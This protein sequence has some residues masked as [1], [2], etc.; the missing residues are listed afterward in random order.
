MAQ[1]TINATDPLESTS[2]GKINDNF[3]ELYAHKADTANPH[4]TTKTQVGLANVDN[5]QQLPISYLD[6]DTGL[7]ANSDTKVA[8]Q[9]ATKAYADT[10][11]VNPMSAAGD[12]IYGGASGA[13]TRLAK[14]S[15][16]QVLKMNSGATA[17]EWGDASSGGTTTMPTQRVWSD[18]F[19]VSRTSD[20]VITY[21]A[22]SAAIAT[23]VANS[24]IGRLLRWRNGD[25]SATKRAFVRNATASSTTITINLYG[26]AVAASGAGSTDANLDSFR[27]SLYEIVRIA[28]WYIAGE[29]VADGSNP[30]GKHYRNLTNQDWYILACAAYVETAAVGAGADLTYNIYNGANAIFGTAPTFSTNASVLNSVPSQNNPITG[31]T[32]ITLRTP[33]SAG[34]TNKASDLVVL[35]FYAPDDLWD[36]V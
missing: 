30:V 19:T 22:A 29:Q 16:A 18:V 3:T 6:T 4:A 24:I 35:M 34:A 7:T 31:G 10:K 1:Q 32:A 13:P 17:P 11:M 26:D 25:D 9:K 8:S 36:A 33:A 23:I 2:R 15:A 20:Y 14:G 12:I 28:D 5:V 27:I 21:T